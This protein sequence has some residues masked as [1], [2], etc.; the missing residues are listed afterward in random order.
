MPLALQRST[1]SIGTTD[2]EMPF[3]KKSHTPT[4]KS[5]N[6]K[7]GSILVNFHPK[8]LKMAKESFF[9]SQEKFM[10]AN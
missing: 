3:S 10:K 5:K 8:V 2:R 6:I 9:T 1:G 4:S 7:T